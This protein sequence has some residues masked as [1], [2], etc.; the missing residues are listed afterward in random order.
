MASTV[1]AKPAA[2]GLQHARADVA[3]F[4]ASQKKPGDHGFMR[5]AEDEDGKMNGRRG[6]AARDAGRAAA[7]AR[8]QP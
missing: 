7:G 4:V 1:A 6:D 8:A 5:P 3:P 2:A